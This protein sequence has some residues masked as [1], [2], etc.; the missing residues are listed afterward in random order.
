[1]EGLINWLADLL[2]LA[3]WWPWDY[4][5]S[6]AIIIWIVYGVF[7]SLGLPPVAMIIL[8]WLERK[9]IA[10]IQDRL[11]P[12][13]AGPKG[14]LQAVAD[15]IKML[16]KEDVTPTG[17][18]VLP[19]LLAP[20]LVAISAVLVYAVLP[21]APGVIGVD[22]NI[23]VLYIMAV[24]SFGIL[25]TLMAGWSSNNKYALLGAFRAVAQLVAYEIPMV[26]ALITVTLVA[27]SMSTVAI[28]EQQ[29]WSN[30][31]WF[32]LTMPVTF[33][34]F[35]IS[36][37]AETGRSPFDLLEAES[38]I[39]AGFHVEYSGLKYG[40]FMIGE[41]V[42]A[43][44]VAVLCAVLFLGGWSPLNGDAPPFGSALLGAI[45]GHIILLAKVGIF[46]FIMM[47]MRGTLPRFR[48][49]HLLN[50]GW[51]FLTPLALVNLMVTA[52]VVR[53]FQ[54]G[55]V[56]GTTIEPGPLAQWSAFGPIAL[57]AANVILI[58]LTVVAVRGFAQKGQQAGLR[59]VTAVDAL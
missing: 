44:A 1:M 38:E 53:L 14:L 26:L 12:N 5:M 24:G 6:A 13:R 28:V 30:S 10:R 47:W 40:L 9:I 56:A 51:K 55:N 52:L 22:L 4:H 39:V 17:A 29:S 35:F 27:G 31:G 45:L 37:L 8:T 34:I 59:A 58:I 25:G 16:T 54:P 18:D 41:Y 23:G 15:T 32:G 49:D 2:A 48:I 50:F 57:L 19:F 11:G 3:S 33:M 46:I 43:L 20:G 7:L 42:H 21:V 36:A